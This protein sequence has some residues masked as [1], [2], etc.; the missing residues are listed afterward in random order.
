MNPV[1]K[2]LIKILG[3]L[4]SNYLYILWFILYF[5]I[6]WTL[7]G[8]DGQSFLLVLIIYGT[9]VTIALSPIG[10]F[11]L[12]ITENCR[13]PVTEEE[14]NYLVPMFEEVYENTKEIYP[15]INKNIKIYITDDM[16]VNA[17]A[18]GRKT[19]AVTMGALQT[20]SAEELKG[21]IAHEFGH[22]MHGHTKALLLSVVGNMLFSIIVLIF[23]LIFIVV[24]IICEIVANFNWLGCA[25]SIFNIVASLLV[26][27]SVFL[28]INLS[29]I[30]LSL[31]SRANEFQA[32]TFAYEVGY[33]I[34]L[35]KALYL[36]EK[37]SMNTR[38]SLS[39]KLKASHPHTAKRIEN[40]ER[41][42]NQEIEETTGTITA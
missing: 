16:Y 26:E 19:I 24:Q 14:K 13:E 31:N 15:G 35:T 5:T 10:E 27:I 8:G 18:I 39:Q 34:E 23:R 21:V 3:I 25:F 30:I 2:F 29:Q 6:A 12:R 40:L 38:P 42:E 17:F 22:L 33:G 4:E 37:I 11:I 32:D 1:I 7:F 36:I 20:F 28:F 9:S 41:L